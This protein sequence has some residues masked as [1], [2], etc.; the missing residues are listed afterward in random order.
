MPIKSKPGTSSRHA[1]SANDW[2]N[3]LAPE[4]EIVAN[5]WAKTAWLGLK[6]V[7]HHSIPDPAAWIFIDKPWPKPSSQARLI[8]GK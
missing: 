1:Y 3:N 6:S 4:P 7:P 8:S 5:S 2:S